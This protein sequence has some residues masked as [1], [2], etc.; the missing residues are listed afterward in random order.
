MPTSALELPRETAL[1]AVECQKG[2]LDPAGRFNPLWR[3][4]EEKGMVPAIAR[5]AAACRDTGRSVV[6]CL[7]VARPDGGGRSSNAPL[8]RTST[9]GLVAG[10]ERAEVVEPLRPEPA[11]YVVA[12]H[13]GVSPFH[14]TE[15][16]SILR[17]L[18]V[19]TIVATG[20]SVNVA[21]TG[22]VIEAV[23][24]GYEVVV[25]TDAIAGAP[26]DYEQA[27]IQYCLRHLARLSTAAEVCAALRA[28]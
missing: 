4:S 9:D 8:L 6:H 23:N 3:R 12:R 13:H 18:G 22:M 15:L 1:L 26:A 20:V 16:D 2:V 7:A 11:D 25:P 10:T 21:L 24:F 14:G 27:Q 17:N 5:I 28:R 19:R